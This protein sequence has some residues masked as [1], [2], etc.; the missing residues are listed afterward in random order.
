MVSPTPMKH[1]FV[2]A[3]A[4]AYRR[5]AWATPPPLSESPGAPRTA[6]RSGC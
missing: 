2:R 4:K 6:A 1:F 3:G 5:R